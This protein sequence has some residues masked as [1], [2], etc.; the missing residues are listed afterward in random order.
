MRRGCYTASL[1]ISN[2]F[3]KDVATRAV[4]EVALSLD[5]TDGISVET[6]CTAVNGALRASALEYAAIREQPGNLQI[7]DVTLYPQ[8]VLFK[9]E[10]LGP[11]WPNLALPP[12]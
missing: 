8:S 3:S 7:R 12:S 11:I 6:L 4:P 2:Q 1:I 10:G 9:A 5:N